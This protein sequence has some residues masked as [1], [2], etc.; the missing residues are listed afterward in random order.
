MKEEARVETPIYEEGNL[1]WI[2]TIVNGTHA[3]LPIHAPSFEDAERMA[4][5]V[6]RLIKALYRK[7]YHDGYASCQQVIK[8][9]LGLPP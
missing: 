9:A 4:P 6:E 5:E 2:A 7:A 3:N 8:D 1:V